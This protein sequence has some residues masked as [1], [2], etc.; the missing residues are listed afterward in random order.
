M[1]GRSMLLIS[2]VRNDEVRRL[3]GQPKLTAI[4]QSRRPTLFGHIVCVDDNTDAKRILSV[5]PLEHWRRLR[6]RPLH[7]MAGHR[8]AGSEIPQSHTAS[9]SGYGLE[10]VSVEDVIDVWRYTI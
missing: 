6:S 9:S 7:H 3:T 4:V 10:P 1:H 2:G 8:T 5:L